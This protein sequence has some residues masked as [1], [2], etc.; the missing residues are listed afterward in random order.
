MIWD[1]HPPPWQPSPGEYYASGLLTGSGAL[2]LYCRSPEAYQRHILNAWKDIAQGRVVTAGKPS[3]AM[4]LGSAVDCMLT[5]PGQ[6]RSRFVVTDSKRESHVG[7]DKMTPAAYVKAR[8]MAAAV[9]RH[10]R[11]REL[12]HRPCLRQVCHHWQVDG[13]CYRLRADFVAQA[14]D[15]TVILQDL[16]AWDVDVTEEWQVRRHAKRLGTYIQM[17]LYGQGIED[18][19][20]RFPIIALII[21]SSRSPHKV[22]V[23][24]LFGQ[25]FAAARTQV[26]EAQKGIAEAFMTGVFCDRMDEEIRAL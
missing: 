7:R 13:I 17:A 14:N 25:D 4:V 12:I 1:D 18:L 19:W 20:G 23:R 26:A 9:D 16:K 6:F 15:G 11:A 22:V 2:K 3:A 5:E 8:K 21:V 24:Y 10:P